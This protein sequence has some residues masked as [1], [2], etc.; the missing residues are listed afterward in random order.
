MQER[1]KKG[2]K[3]GRIPEN[4]GAAERRK[5]VKGFAAAALLTLCFWSVIYPEFTFAPGVC[6][7]A[8]GSAMSGQDYERLLNAQAGELRI[9]FSFQKEKRTEDQAS[10]EMQEDREEDNVGI[11]GMQEKARRGF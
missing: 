5:Q 4:G 9:V 6:R 7:K 1:R 2:R 11:T 10:S 8:D 3:T